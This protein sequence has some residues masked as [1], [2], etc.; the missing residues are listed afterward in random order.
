MNENNYERCLKIFM[1]KQENA[2]YFFK[3]LTLLVYIVLVRS[4]IRSEQ[5]FKFIKHLSHMVQRVYT[6]I[7]YI[8]CVIRYHTPCIYNDKTTRE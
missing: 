8:V 6:N 2:R 4:P 5:L 7:R 1:K 3:Q